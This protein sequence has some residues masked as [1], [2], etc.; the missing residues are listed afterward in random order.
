MPKANLY[1]PIVTIGFGFGER[2][3]FGVVDFVGEVQRDCGS[4]LDQ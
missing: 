2:R 1:I 3:F 4:G